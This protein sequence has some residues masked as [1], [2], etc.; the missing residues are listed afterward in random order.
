M[1]E[2][3]SLKDGSGIIEIAIDVLALSLSFIHVDG[4]CGI[5]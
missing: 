2:C 3:A 5:P 4:K 1:I